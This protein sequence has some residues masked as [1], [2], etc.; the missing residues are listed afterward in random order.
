MASPFF[1]SLLTASSTKPRAKLSTEPIDIDKIVRDVPNGDRWLRHLHE[2]LLPFWTTEIALGTPIGNFPT[3][4]HNDGSAVDPRNPGADT[5]KWATPGIGGNP[6]IDS[7]Q[8]FKNAAVPEGVFFSPPGT[9]YSVVVDDNLITCRTTPDGYPGVLAL[10]A[11][12][13]GSPPLR[14]CLFIDADERGRKTPRRTAD[15]P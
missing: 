3:C 15:A 9:P 8:L 11:M 6:L 2:D 12:M 14:G 10:I 5:E 1:L 7:E 13:D 4:R